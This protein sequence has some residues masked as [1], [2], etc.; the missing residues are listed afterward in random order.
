MK[1]KRKD[2]DPSQNKESSQGKEEEAMPE[3]PS[4]A[5][6]E[7]KRLRKENKALE[8]KLT[9]LMADLTNIRRRQAEELLR[10]RETSM[11][12]LANELL[13]IVD[14]FELALKAG[15]DRES[16]M[17]GVQMV[18]SMLT[19]MMGRH[20]IQ[21]IPALEAPFDPSRHEALAVQENE[22]VP[23]GT[24]LQV[25]QEGYEMGDRVLRPARVVVSQ[26]PNKEENPENTGKDPDSDA[27]EE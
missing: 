5:F 10:A 4:Q 21:K 6:E 12:R 18:H 22:D 20:G 8:E 2:Q 1:R 17:E 15:G 11:E 14:S 13:P 27:P 26:N 7:I 23:H 25:H 3:D 24:V 16:I 19:D 9:R